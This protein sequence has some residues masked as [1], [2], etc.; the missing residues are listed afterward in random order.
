MAATVVLLV[1]YPALPQGSGLVFVM[2][3]G[4]NLFVLLAGYA[5]SIMLT[6]RAL[7]RRG[8][9][10]WYGTLATMPFYW[11]LMPLA[12]WLALWQFL[13]RPFHWN[14]TEHGLSAQQ[15]IK[16]RPVHRTG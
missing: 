11:M 8:F 4:V 5:I 7:L 16:P 13:T 3:S 14:K 1:A 9:L 2:L 12:A 6:R 10:G 15:R